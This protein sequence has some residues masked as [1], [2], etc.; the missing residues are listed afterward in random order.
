MTV[1]DAIQLGLL[2]GQ[3]AALGIPAAKK[4]AGQIEAMVKEGRDPTAEEWDGLNKVGAEVR[5]RL[6]D[7]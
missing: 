3:A 4:A 5:R 7:A 1:R 2:L 6:L